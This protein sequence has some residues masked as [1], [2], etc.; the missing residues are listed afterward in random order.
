MNENILVNQMSSINK[1]AYIY[2]IIKKRKMENYPS[3]GKEIENIV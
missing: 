3:D 1:T 2:S